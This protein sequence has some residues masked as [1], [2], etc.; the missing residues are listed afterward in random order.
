[1]GTVPRTDIIYRRPRPGLLAGGIVLFVAGWV[2]DI[3]FTY[4]YDHQPASTSLIPLVGPFIQLSESYGLD[5]PAVNTGSAEADDR[6]N[7]N[8]DR[9]NSTIRGLAITGAVVSGAMQLTGLALTI[10]GAV[11]K[12]KI[13]HYALGALGGRFRF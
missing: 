3:G 7:K 10:A 11:T 9:S 12:R 4:G 1:V 2:A 8:L 5:G 6:I 13:T